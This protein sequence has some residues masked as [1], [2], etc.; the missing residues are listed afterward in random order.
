MGSA[1]ASR[2]LTAAQPGDRRHEQGQ[3][4]GF[5]RECEPAAGPGG[6]PS[7][8]HAFWQGPCGHLLGRRSAGGD[9]GERARHGCLRHPAH[10]RTDRRAFHGVAG[11]GGRA[12]ARFGGQC[13][14]GGAVFRLCPAGPPPAFGA[15]AD[16]RQGRGQ[17]VHR[18]GHRPAHVG[19]QCAGTSPSARPRATSR[20]CSR[21]QRTGG[22]A[23]VRS[24]QSW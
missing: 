8:R 16:H 15:G 19:P 5:H 20:T 22:E 21:S 23:W 1:E 24:C 4:A 9:R 3:H 17:D 10:Q 7:A 6:L 14:R 12:Q 18:G 13:D 2:A 11:A